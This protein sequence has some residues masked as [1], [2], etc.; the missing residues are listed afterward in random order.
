MLAEHPE[1]C[2]ALGCINF[3]LVG[4]VLCKKRL[5]FS[6]STLITLSVCLQDYVGETPIHKA[7]R[8]GSME[9]I[10]A[11]LLHGAKPE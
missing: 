3:L 9:C 7:A 11:L 8:A 1:D 5:L 10:T 6:P 2:K 4:G